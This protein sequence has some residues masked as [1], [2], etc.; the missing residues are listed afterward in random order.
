MDETSQDHV[1]PRLRARAV[2]FHEQTADIEIGSRIARSRGTCVRP[3]D[4]HGLADGGLSITTNDGATTV[5]DPTTVAA[6][7]AEWATGDK[8]AS[9][10]AFV[11]AQ[12]AGRRSIRL[13]RKLG[14]DHA[15]VPFFYRDEAGMTR[16]GSKPITLAPRRATGGRGV[17]RAAGQSTN[18][19]S[20]GTR[21]TAASSSTAGADPGDPDP[22]LP[23]PRLRPV[24]SRA[25][26]AFR[27]LTTD[28]RG[29]VDRRLSGDVPHAGEHKQPTRSCDELDE[30]SSYEHEGPL[31]SQHW[32]RALE[33]LRPGWTERTLQDH[34]AQREHSREIEKRTL[35]YDHKRFQS[36]AT[37][38]VLRLVIASGLAF[39]VIVAGIALIVSEKP[40][41]DFVLL[42]GGI[43]T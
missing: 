38:Q 12:D 24:L 39:L 5:V 23:G 36:L 27:R 31:P 40:T 30:G 21:R 7:R 29:A 3:A 25:V 13:A 37:Y 8:L 11:K 9:A 1:P 42:V 34:E 26:H 41:P 2:A 20:A 18:H 28:Q 32:L 4:I 6:E 43:A 22:A 10:I 16:T 14:R 35:E 15:H 19:R 17:G 33:D